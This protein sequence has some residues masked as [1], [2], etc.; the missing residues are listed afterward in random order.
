MIFSDGITVL[1]KGLV[2]FLEV[3]TL[4]EEQNKV[5]LSRDKSRD[6]NY[7]C[8]PILC[9]YYT[10]CNPKSKMMSWKAGNGNPA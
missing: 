2:I 4:S 8:F 3:I 5:E 7:L 10:L 9:H 1:Q 6:R